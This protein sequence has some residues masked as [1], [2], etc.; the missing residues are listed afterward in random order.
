MSALP[1]ELQSAEERFAEDYRLA[2]D[3]F[4]RHMRRQG[5]LV[6]DRILE[7]AHDKATERATAAARFR[8]QRSID[9]RSMSRACLQ[10]SLTWYGY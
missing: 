5:Y 2:F 10:R 9:V 1:V 6:S 7:G 4:V 3:D 8:G